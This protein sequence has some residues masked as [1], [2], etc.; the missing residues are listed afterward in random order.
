M[1]LRVILEGFGGHFGGSEIRNWSWSER[2]V[3]RSSGGRSRGSH[4]DLKSGKNRHI[5]GSCGWRTGL[6]GQ[7]RR[8]AARR[9]LKTHPKVGLKSGKMPHFESQPLVVSHSKIVEPSITLSFIIKLIDFEYQF[10]SKMMQLH[11][12]Q[13][14]GWFWG[15]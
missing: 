7:R 13:S 12:S 6:R 15:G 10:D 8:E 2:R 4:F 5:L 9:C 1:I 11:L 14:W 3:G